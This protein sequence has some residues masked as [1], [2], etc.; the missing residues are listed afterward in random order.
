MPPPPPPFFGPAAGGIEPT[1]PFSFVPKS[2]K[3]DEELKRYEG[4]M[5]DICE[6]VALKH[7][8]SLKA[9]HGTGRNVAPFV[10]MEWGTKAYQLM[11][12]VSRPSELLRSRNCSAGEPRA[13][14]CVTTQHPPSSPQVK[15]LFDP[16]FL[17]N[18][19]VVLNEVCSCFVCVASP[20]SL[21]G[22]VFVAAGSGRARQEHPL[23][24]S[25]QPA[26]RSLHFLRLVR[27]QLPLQGFV[28]HPAA[29]YPSVQGDESHAGGVHGERSVDEAGLPPRA[30]S[31]PHQRGRARQIWRCHVRALHTRR[32]QLL[33]PH[34]ALPREEA[35][36]FAHAAAF[37]A[38]RSAS[39]PS[40]SRGI[41]LNR[42]VPLTAC[43]RRSAPSRSTPGS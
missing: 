13:C 25:R 6:N 42:R 4:L 11:W 41:T 29:A 32:A 34:L 35:W 26:H 20:A 22:S 3:T 43:A 28:P 33:Q 23:R 24:P 2:F 19:G 10:E 15:Q 18:P 31:P 30:P 16:Q 9:E 12:E 7:G 37:C 39:W 5:Y 38:R 17:L 36:A 1:C 27:V 21:E 8:G 14:A 40:S